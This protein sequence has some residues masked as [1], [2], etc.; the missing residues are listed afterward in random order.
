MWN[1]IGTALGFIGDLLRITSSSNSQAQSKKAKDNTSNANQ[2]VIPVQNASN[3][4]HQQQVI[5]ANN[6]TAQ[7]VIR[8]V[9]KK[10]MSQT[11]PVIATSQPTIKKAN[12]RSSR[13]N[14]LPDIN[15]HRNID[16][17]GLLAI[18]PQNKNDLS[19]KWRR[20]KTSDI[21]NLTGFKNITDDN[22]GILKFITENRKH[23]LHVSPDNMVLKGTEPVDKVTCE[24]LLLAACATYGNNLMLYAG[25][26][27]LR[28]QLKQTATSLGINVTITKTIEE[29]NNKEKN[30]SKPQIQ[31][32][33]TSS[34]PS[35]DNRVKKDQTTTNATQSSQVTASLTPALRMS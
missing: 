31:H 10:P 9:Q 3:N 2:P 11:T 6:Q 28:E 19:V 12:F 26:E 13:S 30:T 23:T 15:K 4:N 22:S 33:A 17:N 8:P 20:E 7:Q 21:A 29:F 16:L 34:T 14:S 18:K 24:K 27:K 32:N 35:D 25:E 1:A 5:S